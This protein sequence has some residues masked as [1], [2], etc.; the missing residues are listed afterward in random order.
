MNLPQFLKQ[1]D[2]QTN[3]MSKSELEAFIHELARTLSENKRKNF[4]DTIQIS[5][6][7][8]A[9]SAADASH[10]ATF[11]GEL[12]HMVDILTDINNGERTLDSEYNEDW[13]DWYN[14]DAEQVLFL[15]PEHLL[16]DIQDGIDMIHKSIDAENYALGCELAET[17]SALEVFV[18]GDYNDYDGS[19][20]GVT[21]LYEH[22]LLS[23]S[24]KDV[25]R[26][27]IFLTYMGNKPADR[28]EEMFCMMGNF[29][30]FDVSL[31]EI[32]QLGSHDLP[33]FDEF[34]PLWIDYL[35]NQTERRSKKLLLEAQEMVEDEEQILEAARKFANR[36]PELYL[37][38]LEKNR[39]CSEGNRYFYIGME[40]M[41][42]LPENWIIRSEIALLTAEYALK[43]NDRK[44]SE[45]CW[46]EAFRSDASVVN[47]MRLRF[48]TEDWHKYH[49]Q[50]RQIYRNSYEKTKTIVRNYSLHA[51][52]DAQRET[53]L[54]DTGY[55]SIM[56]FEEEFESVQ[57]E[58]VNE[59]SALG[60]SSTFMKEGLALF[61]LLIYNGRDL[62]K[63]LSA[64]RSRAI[65]ACAFQVEAFQKGTKIKYGKED[66][67]DVFWDLFCEWKHECE[68]SDEDAE[69]WLED[70][71][72]QME[73]RTE[74]IME[75]NRRNYY[76]ECA[77]YIAAIGEVEESRGKENAKERLME[78]YKKKYSRRRAF[79][80]ELRN[81]GLKK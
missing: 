2:S 23:G 8:V 39:N 35:G 50:V 28:V 53:S 31:E 40:A 18:D 11:S 54:Y 15:D 17:L 7:R 62:P 72:R 5:T 57:N 3:R 6:Q 79:H 52:L 21:E 63:G 56:F 37:Q 1:V 61:L 30:C 80:Q 66:N 65:S 78:Y 43:K 67:N 76:G 27:S 10:A 77:S 29:R 12:R 36:H 48:C 59:K 33:D 51:L 49:E 4:L 75:N 68:L 9:G 46:L 73:R 26:E 42:K 60:W 69:R 14:S 16:P 38:I 34:L 13:D 22:G 55:F 81:Y 74:G 71:K 58:A 25:V 20:V 19:P 44:V 64:M 32:M 24:L 47:Y 45:S 41:E 70:M